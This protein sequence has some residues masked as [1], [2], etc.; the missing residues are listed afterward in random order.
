MMFERQK[1]PSGQTPNWV[2]LDENGV[3]FDEDKI[4]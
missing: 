3:E 4:D 2:P 1:D